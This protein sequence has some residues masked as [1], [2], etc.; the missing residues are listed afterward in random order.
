MSFNPDPNKQA[1]ELLFSHKINSLITLLYISTIK[2]LHRKYACAQEANKRGAYAH[3]YAHIY[4]HM[5]AREA[6]RLRSYI[7]THTYTT[8]LGKPIER[9]SDHYTYAHIHVHAREANTRG[10]LRV[11]FPLLLFVCACMCV[12][13]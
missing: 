1:T 7:C 10:G 5:H 6:N 13:S 8:L 4:M 2:T 9:E 11:F 3:I 12:I